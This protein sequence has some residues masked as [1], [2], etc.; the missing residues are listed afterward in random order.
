[1]KEDDTFM[2]NEQ[3]EKLVRNI[4][5]IGVIK[6]IS[7][8]DDYIIDGVLG[9]INRK[10]EL[11]E[12]YNISYQELKDLLIRILSNDNTKAKKYVLLSLT[13]EDLL[14][15]RSFTE[16]NR[17]SDIIMGTYKDIDF[18]VR[19]QA[20]TN[21]RILSIL[22]F[23]IHYKLL[24]GTAGDIRNR[25]A[26]LDIAVFN[27]SDFNDSEYKNKLINIIMNISDSECLNHLT[28]SFGYRF[29]YNTETYYKK[30]LYYISQFKNNEQIKRI[31]H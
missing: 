9:I 27:C 29:K 8:Q 17:L 7:E 4:D 25:M 1:M 30:I 20:L 19:G 5:D 6:L 10:E 16:I 18:E 24:N 22:P 2:N 26:L 11:R 21:K 12:K 3:L 13:N 15:N 23:E 28:S 14:S 31:V